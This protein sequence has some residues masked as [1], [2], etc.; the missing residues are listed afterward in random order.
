[1]E[2]LTSILQIQMGGNKRIDGLTNIYGH[3]TKVF[4][5]RKSWMLALFF[6]PAVSFSC[7]FDLD[8]SIGSQCI[9]EPG[10]M[11]GYCAGGMNPGNGNDERPARSSLDINGTGGD[12]CHFNLDCGPGGKCLKESGYLNG[13][14]V[15]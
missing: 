2:L 12:T 11:Y 15:N 13:V 7:A 6:V 14:C 1:M 9:K 3:S 8:C 5:M 4:E 10:S